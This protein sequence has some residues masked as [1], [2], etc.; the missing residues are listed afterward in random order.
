MAL[1]IGLLC[2]VHIL[3]SLLHLYLC[4]L[5]PGHRSVCH[6]PSVVSANQ[7][8]FMYVQP[9]LRHDLSDEGQPLPGGVA[10]RLLF[11]LLTGLYLM[12]LCLDTYSHEATFT[13]ASLYGCASE[14]SAHKW[15]LPS[16]KLTANGRLAPVIMT[17]V[18]QTC[19]HH[20]KC[21]EDSVL[22]GKDAEGGMIC[23]ELQK[24]SKRQQKNTLEIFYSWKAEWLS[25]VLISKWQMYDTRHFMYVWSERAHFCQK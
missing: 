20:W 5:T 3:F 2:S 6:F 1:R 14:W 10:L 16:G 22:C 12:M 18:H 24:V 17:A 9:F 19:I 4:L 13:T 25:Y 7:Y 11:L 15:V 23:N 21:S 8:F